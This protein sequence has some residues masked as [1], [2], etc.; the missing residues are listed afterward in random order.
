MLRNQNI[1]YIPGINIIIEGFTFDLL[2]L[3]KLFEDSFT[4]E[5]GMTFMTI[6]NYGH[7]NQ[8]SGS[9]DRLVQFHL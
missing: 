2:S 3:V 4:S 1:N 9:I 8:M 7:E 5:Q 6:R